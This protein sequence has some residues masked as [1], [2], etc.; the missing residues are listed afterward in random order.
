[1]VETV[2]LKDELLDQFK[3]LASYI[4]E[5]KYPEID[6]IAQRTMAYEKIAEITKYDIGT[7]RSKWS[8]KE[9][10][11]RYDDLKFFC[12]NFLAYYSQFSDQLPEQKQEHYD[13]FVTWVTN[14]CKTKD[15][16]KEPFLMVANK[17]K[18]VKVFLSSISDDEN[19][20]EQSGE[21][22]G[23]TNSD[24]HTSILAND[25]VDVIE[26]D[27]K[28]NV[29]NI[30]ENEDFQVNKDHGTEF[31]EKKLPHII[32]RMPSSDEHHANGIIFL[33]IDDLTVI[34]KK[35]GYEVGDLVIEGISSIIHRRSAFRYS[36]RC[37][38]DT[39][40][41]VLFR[42]N[43]GKS[44]ELCEKIKKDIS[45]YPWKSVA[46]KL[47]VTCT[48]GSALMK[49]DED[50]YSWFERSIIGMLEG[51]EKG[52]NIIQTGPLFLSRKETKVLEE[53]E[54]EKSKAR[55]KRE[56]YFSLRQWFS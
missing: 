5:L 26:R 42:T 29:N 7:I 40:Y 8:Q 1:M 22:I 41:G 37:G 12:E 2:K 44:Y 52:G 35:F 15:W 18:S 4:I 28:T 27:A 51:K 33:D 20:E 17:E 24:V 16:K 31:I 3:R 45:Y 46:D 14:V 53:A 25:F 47:R 9:P 50:P 21:H 11:I 54:E 34:N 38:D 13:L 10:V 39:F 30:D 43:S 56:Y 48:I 36:G 49:K 55:E 23:N 32:L 6:F 19:K